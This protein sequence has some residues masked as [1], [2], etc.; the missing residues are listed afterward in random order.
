MEKTERYSQRKSYESDVGY[1]YLG[2]GSCARS[3]MRYF[4]VGDGWRTYVVRET[5]RVDDG[6]EN[7]VG[8]RV[9]HGHGFWT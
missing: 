7:V 2:L 5:S 6:F 3:H 4:R 9:G 1:R 8:N